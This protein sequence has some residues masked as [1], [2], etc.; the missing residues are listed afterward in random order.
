M[1]LV[2]GTGCMLTAAMAPA[3]PVWT[4]ARRFTSIDI[5]GAKAAAEPA[6]ARTAV[7][8][9]S[10]LMSFKVPNK[11]YTF[12]HF[13][14]GISLR[15]PQPNY[16]RTKYLK[17]NSHLMCPST[18]FLKKEFFTGLAGNTWISNS[19]RKQFLLHH[20]KTRTPPCCVP[21]QPSP[22]RA[23]PPPSRR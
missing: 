16:H 17:L 18:S 23:P 14:Y 21:P 12:F 10:I 11:V 4:T 8:R 5:I 22:S 15:F 2:G 13:C 20:K 19:S 3:T 6:S 1:R 9:P 7:E